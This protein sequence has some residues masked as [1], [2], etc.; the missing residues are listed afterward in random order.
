[1]QAEGLARE[2]LDF[3]EQK[4]LD[5]WERFRATSLWGASLAGQKKFAEAE[6]LLIEGYQGMLS[7]KNEMAVSYWY[8]LDR[9]RLWLAL[10]YQAW[11]KPESA[12]AW[13]NNQQ[14]R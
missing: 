6:P 13:Q 8:H 5:N 12:A 4:Q 7:R 14:Q 11:G 3:A 1:M 9:A 10:L 2:T